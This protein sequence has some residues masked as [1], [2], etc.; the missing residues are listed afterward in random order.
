MFPIAACLP[1]GTKSSARYSLEARQFFSRLATPPSDARAT[2]YARFIDLLVFSG[3]WAKGDGCYLAAAVDTATSLINLISSS[4][5]LNPVGSPTFAADGGYIGNAGA[6]KYLDTQFDPTA[7]VSPKFTK[8]DNA[9]FAWRNTTDAAG[10]DG[11]AGID[12]NT[13]LLIDQLDAGNNVYLASSGGYTGGTQKAQYTGLYGASRRA[14]TP[15]VQHGWLR[16]VEICTN[17]AAANNN[18]VAGRK[19]TLLKDGNGDGCITQVSG[20]FIGGADFNAS[21]ARNLSV[22]FANYMQDLAGGA[23]PTQLGYSTDI[24]ADGAA[25]INPSVCKLAD[26]RYLAVWGIGETNGYLAYS[27]STDKKTWAAPTT[28]ATPAAAHSYLDPLVKQTSTGKILV[29]CHYAADDASTDVVKIIPATLSGLTINWGTEISPTSSFV[30]LFATAAP[31]VELA[32]GELVLAIYKTGV[33]LLKSTDGGLTWP[34]EIT[35][36]T[37]GGGHTWNEFQFVE[38]SPGNLYGIVRNDGA[39]NVGYWD[40]SSSNSGAIWGSPTK[41]LDATVAPVPSRPALSLTPGGTVFMVSRFKG[42]SNNESGYS[43]KTS[44]GAWIAPVILYNAA[45]IS[46]GQ[47]TGSQG[48]YDVAT[49]KITYVIGVGSFLASKVVLQDF[50]VPV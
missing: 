32:N 48:I 38:T 27:T 46:S 9:L 20:A 28:F 2:I 5:A 3:V 34:T 37:N 21:D 44:G 15:T 33:H 11:I 16:G 47:H 14:G 10:A 7:A 13:F 17:N 1:K 26:G 31:V 45:N 35:V 49:G 30:T 43:Y 18:F 24:I 40:I 50:Y 12:G 36:L 41:V 8:P 25:N 6:T 4:Y 22:A 39:G 29:A 23:R 42:V 19:V